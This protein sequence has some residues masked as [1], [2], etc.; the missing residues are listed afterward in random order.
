MPLTLPTGFYDVTL[1]PYMAR[2]DGSADAA[3]AI[4]QAINDA[5]TSR[6]QV[7][8]R[9]IKGGVVW[10]PAGAYWIDSPLVIPGG[11]TLAGVG[12]ADEF[13]GTW[14]IITKTEPFVPLL[15]EGGV[16]RD[17]AFYHHYEVAEAPTVG[18]DWSPK[19]YNW[20]IVGTGNVQVKNVMMKNPTRGL[21]LSGRFT[22][23]DFWAH[24]IYRP[25][26]I[27]NFGSNDVCH[28]D[29]IHL[30]SFWYGKSNELET[31]TLKNAIG[32]VCNG[33]DNPLLSNIFV[34]RCHIGILFGGS[35]KTSRFHL[36]NV[37]LDS[38]A[39]GVQITTNKTEGQIAN[40]IATGTTNNDK[41]WVFGKRSG[42]VA[43]AEHISIQC[44]NVEFGNYCENCIDARGEGTRLY[45][46]NLIC[47]QWSLEQAGRHAAI[48]AMNGAT[49]RVSNDCK[50]IEPP[51]SQDR[52]ADGDVQF[53]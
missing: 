14:L 19:P 42:M 27:E 53:G 47:K 46:Q 16:I 39:Y 33:A 10:L 8:G 38:C 45:F 7:F 18:R 1:P 2:C 31:Y 26:E 51:T 34:Q 36:C 22:V 15:A 13:A 49:V 41:E 40:L 52:E 24:P 44:S 25:L 48:A 30:W 17:L 32:V 23:R 11:I 20:T 6:A 43:T 9:E 3:P 21:Q 35:R 50:H 29:H 4:Q 5:M 28:V 12:W 37:D